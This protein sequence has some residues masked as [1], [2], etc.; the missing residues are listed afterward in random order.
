MKYVKFMKIHNTSLYY[1]VLI[2]ILK[3]GLLNVTIR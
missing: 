3:T 2:Y 1:F